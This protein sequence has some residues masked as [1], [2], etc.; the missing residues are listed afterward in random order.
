M[1][2][3]FLGGL[4]KN[5]TFSLNDL[6]G[7][8]NSTATYQRLAAAKVTFIYLGLDDQEILS[9]HAQLYNAIR[10]LNVAFQNDQVTVYSFNA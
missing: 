9:Q 10:A 7:L 8:K 6:Y 3:T 1:K 5:Q 2:L 4:L